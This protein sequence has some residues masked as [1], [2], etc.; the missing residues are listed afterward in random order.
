MATIARRPLSPAG[1]VNIAG[2][3]WTAFTSCPLSCPFYEAGSVKQRARQIGLSGY[4]LSGDSIWLI[5]RL[6]RIKGIKRDGYWDKA[7]RLLIWDSQC[8][9]ERT[10][11]SKG[12]RL[13]S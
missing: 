13:L 10:S 7:G 9:P 3:E 5:D 4:P 8:G 6:K 11:E 2:I 1:F 12:D